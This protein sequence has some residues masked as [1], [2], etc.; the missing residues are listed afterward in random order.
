MDWNWHYVNW[1]VK[2]PDLP[3]K[4]CEVLCRCISPDIDGTPVVTY[5]VQIFLFDCTNG[6]GGKGSFACGNGNR[7][8]THWAYF[9][10]PAYVK[11]EY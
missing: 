5:E 4:N 1:D 3:D 8:I 7:I 2:H 9:D 6:K 11:D 10:K